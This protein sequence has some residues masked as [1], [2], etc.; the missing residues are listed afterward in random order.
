[1]DDNG[2]NGRRVRSQ[3]EDVAGELTICLHSMGRDRYVAHE[4]GGGS[5]S[6]E[7][8]LSAMSGD[9]TFVSETVQEGL[10][11]DVQ[12]MEGLVAPANS[13][14]GSTTSDSSLGATSCTWSISR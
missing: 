4:A 7:S 6:S 10:K 8:D 11:W 3:L 1:M 14:Q 12:E 9:D 5:E 2:A 13:S